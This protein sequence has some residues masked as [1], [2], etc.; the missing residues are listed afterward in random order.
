MSD[1]LDRLVTK[2]IGGETPLAP[3]LPSLFE[4]RQRA[5]VMPLTEDGD[6]SPR[7]TAARLE[8]TDV[9]SAA[10]R[11][12]L[13]RSPGSEPTM[14]RVA[15][16]E[17][18]AASVTTPVA[19]LSAA[20]VS[21][22][23]SP[24]PVSARL[25]VPASPV[26]PRAAAEQAQTHLPPPVP[27]RQTRITAEPHEPSRPPAVGILLPSQAS[28][29]ASPHAA[30]PPGRSVDAASRRSSV[31]Q[32]ADRGNAASETVVHVSIGRLEVRAAAASSAP[33][34]RRDRPRSNSLDDYLRQRGDKVSP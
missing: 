8:V 19:A 20:E 15:P 17:R 25:S 24:V 32:A 2:A 34:R 22:Q 30:S 14:R 13:R 3:R 27:P 18:A 7:P 28:V 6:A 12:A 10:I 33:P 21:P 29:F 31:A 16:V 1:F 5:P 9:S 11:Q 26:A 4:P 23:A